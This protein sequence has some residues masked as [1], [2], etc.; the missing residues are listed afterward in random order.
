[1]I[2]SNTRMQQ[3]LPILGISYTSEIYGQVVD[4]YSTC[5]KLLCDPQ[6]Q[7]GVNAMDANLTRTYSPREEI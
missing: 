5:I 4:A 1:M 3:H 7:T 2:K 6:T